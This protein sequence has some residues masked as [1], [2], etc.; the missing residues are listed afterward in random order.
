MVF[1]RKLILRVGINYYM[2]FVLVKI[3]SREKQK[4]TIGREHVNELNEKQETINKQPKQ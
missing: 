1:L 3:N 2:C 4:Q